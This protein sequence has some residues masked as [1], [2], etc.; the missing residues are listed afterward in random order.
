MPGTAGGTTRS[1]DFTVAEPI[2]RMSRCRQL[3]QKHEHLMA[4]HM[5]LYGAGC[6]ESWLVNTSAVSR[7]QSPNAAPIGPN[8]REA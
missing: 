1:S 7:E 6:C 8:S 2:C 5:Q 4:R 3:Q